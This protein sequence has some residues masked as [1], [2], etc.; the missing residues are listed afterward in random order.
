MLSRKH[1]PL[2]ASLLA[3]GSLSVTG[4]AWRHPAIPDAYPVGSVQ[5]SHFHTMQKN[6]EA[7]DYILHLCDFTNETSDLS[8]AG[9]DKLMDIAAK[10]RHAPFPVL[11]ERSENNCNPVLDAERRAVVA[12]ALYE[13]GNTD[14]DQRVVV[15]TPY[16]NGISSVE[17]EI[18]YYRYIFSR[19][20]FG[21]WQT[22]FGGFNGGFN[23]G[24]FG[25]FGGFG[26]WGFGR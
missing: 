2:L 17:G 1:P 19:G 15:A 13:L 4:C 25:G 16:G 7:S 21:G 26:S 23:F 18:D 3:A 12:Q 22:G 11:V 10:M 20:G 6:A 8:P 14:A 9:K 24:G 5:R